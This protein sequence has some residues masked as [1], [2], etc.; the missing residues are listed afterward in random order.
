MKDKGLYI[1]VSLYSLTRWFTEYFKDNKEWFLDNVPCS[2]FRAN[3]LY[4]TFDGLIICLIGWFLYLH[5]I[6]DYTSKAWLFFMVFMG[7]SQGVSYINQQ[8]YNEY[9]DYLPLLLAG[10]LAVEAFKFSKP[11]IIQAYVFVK[12]HIK[13][14]LEFIKTLNQW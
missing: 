12:S 8:L 11:Y 3:V 2:N 10:V 9:L 1:I 6:G 7:I 4:F 5:S 14:Y 13:Q